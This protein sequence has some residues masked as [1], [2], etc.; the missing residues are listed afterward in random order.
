LTRAQLLPDRLLGHFGW[1]FDI[2]RQPVEPRQLRSERFSRSVSLDPEIGAGRLFPLDLQPLAETSALGVAEM[3]DRMREL[4]SEKLGVALDSAQILE[5]NEAVGPRRD[6]LGRHLVEATEVQGE[7]GFVARAGRIHLRDREPTG[8]VGRPT[9]PFGHLHLDDVLTLVD[10]VPEGTERRMARAAAFLPGHHDRHDL[11]P[12]SGLFGRQ[13]VGPKRPRAA[14]WPL[15]RRLRPRE[16]RRFRA[17]DVGNG[18]DDGW[19]QRQQVSRHEALLTDW[20]GNRG[21]KL[22]R[23]SRRTPILFG[24]LE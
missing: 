19:Y 6:R 12:H 4:V 17:G 7:D 3:P 22:Q 11:T 20:G 2:P 18:Q 5:G 10:G 14:P 8:D 24:V 9:L 21:P 1:P 23:P 16:G 15:G 13:T